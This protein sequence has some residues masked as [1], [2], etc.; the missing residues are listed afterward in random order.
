MNLD[1]II[2]Y[3]KANKNQKNIEGMARF[4]IDSSNAYGLTA[5]HLKDLAKKIKKNNELA[6]K[7]W[8]SNIHEG[9]KLA[10]YITD[11][12]KFP[13]DLAD[14]W[15]SETNSWDLCDD[16]CSK[17]LSKTDYCSE[18]VYKWV[19]SDDEFIRRA[20]FALI[21]MM[22]VHRKK[23]RDEEFLQ[24]LPLMIEYSTDERNFVRKAINW[25]LRTFGKRSHF[26]MPIALDT[27]Y[28]MIETFPNSKSAKWIAKDAIR[29]L[30][31][32]KALKN[33]RLNN[34]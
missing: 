13:E 18:K 14:K 24:Y 19:E 23:D 17:V 2:S 33:A 34:L 26:L 5:P 29:E 9:K 15:V 10:I 32:K 3:F 8:N 22:I 25:A 30:E 12:K 27:A 31:E 4:G 28:K 21:A 11:Y 1:E 20:A 6:I 7:L 16:L